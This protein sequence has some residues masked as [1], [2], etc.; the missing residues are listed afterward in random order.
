VNLTAIRVLPPEVANAIAAGEVVER[1]ASVVKE[2]VEN[3]L[4][5]GA[6]RVTVE[7]RGAGR[8]LI[9]VADDGGGIPEGELELAFRRHATSKLSALGDLEAVA[10]L[11][12]RGEALASIAAVAEVECR[13][14]G[15]RIQ[16]RSGQTLE[17][18][19]APPAP[20][21]VTEVR[22]LFANTPARLKFLK[23][24]P[25]ENATALAAV[26]RYALLFPEVRFEAMVEGRRVL[27]TP[28]D[29]TAR[30]AVAAIHGDAVAAEMLEVSAS[31]VRG[32]VSQPR[33]SR[34]SRDGLLLAVNRR[35][36][37][38]RSL[39]YA[40]E[41]CYLGRLERGR[42]P[43]AV[44]DLSVEAGSLDVN[45]H[46]AKREV[47]FRE[48][49]VVFAAIQRAVRGALEGAG[50]YE[51]RLPTSPAPGRLPISP[52]LSR[53]LRLE[54]NP[55]N[56]DVVGEGV[57][58]AAKS[59]P[60]RPLGQVQ[61]GY[62]VAEAPEGLVLI[63]QHAAHE[64]VLYNGYL[65]RLQAGT[66]VSQPFLLPEI[67]ELEPKLVAAAIENQTRLAG[68]GFEIEQFGPRALRVSAAP[69]E[70]PAARAP[71]ALRELLEVLADAR[72]DGQSERLAASL[73]CHSAV[74]FGDQLDPAEQRRLLLELER[75]PDSVTCP[76]GRPT[77]LVIG[78]TDL[79]QHFGRNY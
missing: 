61:D 54:S 67:M 40:V 39:V 27:S 16:L 3:S 7:I 36:V 48:E 37:S 60:L 63:D 38:S 22:D 53:P 42:Y 8:T 11:G 10:S 47:R 75:A 15:R 34:G 55:D 1:P 49:R 23:T 29:G 20:G 65:A 26:M 62:L 72:H 21:T 71:D 43:L 13:S 56:G 17:E 6:H 74:R 52:P 64:R 69:A 19:A 4:D 30:R 35:P 28:G 57:G 76:H 33:L 78:W 14:S 73:A 58:D 45:V 12:F 41:E 25:T 32:F 9:R 46:P 5:A 2:L 18:G 77:R 59:G 68:A 79:R 50:A 70:M 66:S 31:A 44:L 24:D 51:L